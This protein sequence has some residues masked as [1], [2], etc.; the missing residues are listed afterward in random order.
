VD[1]SHY[2]KAMRTGPSNDS[3]VSCHCHVQELMPHLIER[4]HHLALVGDLRRVGVFVQTHQTFWAAKE[5]EQSLRA[6]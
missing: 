4:R 6:A 5:F 1:F 3:F 2:V